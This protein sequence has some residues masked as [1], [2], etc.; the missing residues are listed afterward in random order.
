[1][2]NDQVVFIFFVNRIAASHLFPVK[3][4]FLG[5]ARL[6]ARAALWS[7]SYICCFLPLSWLW[8]SWKIHSP[9]QAGDPLPGRGQTPT[10]FSSGPE[11]P[12]PLDCPLHLDRPPEM[13]WSHQGALHCGAFSHKNKRSLVHGWQRGSVRGVLSGRSCVKFLHSHPND[14]CSNWGNWPSLFAGQWRYCFAHRVQ[15][16]GRWNGQT[17]RW[18]FCWCRCQKRTKT[19][20]HPFGTVYFLVFIGLIT[21]SFVET[22]F[23]FQATING[24]NNK[25]TAKVHRSNSKHGIRSAKLCLQTFLGYLP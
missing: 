10:S 3:V 15:T 16:Q 11:P 4:G 23:S 22:F 25:N 8:S 2:T 7:Q 18:T 19:P 14:C 17:I 5:R 20:F 24:I 13:S 12:S 9:T 6:Q 21:S 1:M